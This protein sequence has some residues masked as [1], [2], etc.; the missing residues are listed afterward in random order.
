M[1]RGSFA[2]AG[3]LMLMFCFVQMLSARLVSFALRFMFSSR[4]F[5]HLSQHLFIDFRRLC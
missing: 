3:S 4:V 1:R 2:L 5:R